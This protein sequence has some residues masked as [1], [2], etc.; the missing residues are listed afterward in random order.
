MT[1]WWVTPPVI[2]HWPSGGFTEYDQLDGRV[3]ASWRRSVRAWEDWTDEDIEAEI[4][5]WN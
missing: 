5:P 2:A 3:I 4:K 1:Y